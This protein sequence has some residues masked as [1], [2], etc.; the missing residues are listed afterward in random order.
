M[1]KPR[2]S[3]VAVVAT[4]VLLAACTGGHDGS[5][6]VAPTSGAGAVER[7]GMDASRQGPAP[8]IEGAA[9]GGKVTVRTG[10]G[11][12]PTCLRPEGC[13]WAPLDPST[14]YFVDTAAVSSGLITRSLT[15]YVWD[16]ESN[17]LI[18]VPDLATDLGRPNAD[19][20][21]WAFT[22]RDGVR[23]EDGTEVTA[24]DVAYGIKRSMDR[25]T[26]PGGPTWGNEYFL[27]G[28]TYQGLYTGGS[29][30]DGVVVDGQTLTIKMARPFPDM[31]YYG[32]FPEMG[33]IPTAGSDPAT[34]GR[35]P[36]ATG[37]YKVEEFVPKKSLT[38]V[39]NPEWDPA[40]DPGRHQYVD[41]YDFLFSQRM[42]PVWPDL[43]ADRPQTQTTLSYDDVPQK[44]IA[45]ARRTAGDRLLEAPTQCLFDAWPDYNKI[46]DLRV[47]QAL[48]YAWPYR[49]NIELQGSIPGVTGLFASSIM[50]PGTAGRLDYSP[51]STRPG[52]TDPAK[53]RMLLAEAGHDPGE[54]RIDLAY[55]AGTPVGRVV[56][57]ALER[58]G[59]HVVAHAYSPTRSTR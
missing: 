53:S 51:L 15:Q 39:R 26:F 14:N 55:L 5:D 44:W 9:S 3:T 27:H 11:W 48:G 4:G 46:D 47:R 33:P 37:P 35:H 36:L 6:D 1:P 59:F 56:V 13:G 38:L 34:Y 42:G 7:V 16:P 17:G 54:Y 45:D 20:T 12:I 19:Y 43:V 52:E 57:P 30:Y 31:P 58:G 2:S 22:I 18:L 49:Q 32:A 28:D 23:F 29:G 21:E 24:A 50:P 8:E 40:T 25:E 41:E 10:F